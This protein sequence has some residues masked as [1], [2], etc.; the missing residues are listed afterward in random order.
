MSDLCNASQQYNKARYL[1]GRN[2][3]IRRLVK[4]FFISKLGTLLDNRTIKTAI[5]R[6]LCTKLYKLHTCPCVY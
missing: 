6:S 3:C 4:C 2:S 1:A 5:F